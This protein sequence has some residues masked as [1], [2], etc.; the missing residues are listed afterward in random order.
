MISTFF[1][2]VYDWTFV[3]QLIAVS[4]S[5]ACVLCPRPR[6]AGG[7]L[8]IT[9]YTVVLYAAETLV[10]LG[11]FC[12]AEYA[13]FLQGINFP[14]AHLAAIVLFAVFFSR[15]KLSARMITGSTVYIFAVSSVELGR[16]LMSY[17]SGLTLPE[18][19]CVAFDLLII[20]AAFF[21]RYFSVADFA[22]IPNSAAAAIL[23]G[24]FLDAVLL[25][26][27]VHGNVGMFALTADTD[28]YVFFEE[29]EM[30]L[31]TII[32]ASSLIT[33]FAV[34]QQCRKNAEMLTM[35]MENE[36][37][38]TNEQMIGI[39]EQAIEEMHE[40]R[41]D[42]GNQLSVLSMLVREKKYGEIEN[43][44][45]GFDS[46]YSGQIRFSKSGNAV[47]D[48]ILNTEILKAAAK[49]IKIVAMVSVP[50]KIGIDGGDLGRILCNLIDN[51]IEESERTDS[52]PK[53]VD[54][55]I[56][57]RTEYLYICVK[58]PMRETAE[59]GR[60]GDSLVETTSKENSGAHGYG[61]KIVKRLVQKYNGSISYSAEDAVFT[62]DAMLE[63]G[64]TGAAA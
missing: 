36:Q 10:N 59:T 21:I 1:S 7:W 33:Y 14:L 52:D 8:K 2:I 37:L 29:V 56:F 27:V 53:T 54:V 26:I 17:F 41:H 46:E 40:I 30:V 32:A 18:L 23:A 4:F 20:G 9:L 19:F 35:E 60:E 42:I 63:M 24:A 15:Q 64:E 6:N 49:K 39:T 58:N 61:H 34:Y 43:Y 44:L 48:S 62:A 57:V 38:R 11:F 5:V 28:L 12:L 47:L 45:K 55:R 16:A 50:E 13:D 51:A 25:L 3:L 31:Y 22:D